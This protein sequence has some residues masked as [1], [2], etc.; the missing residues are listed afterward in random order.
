MNYYIEYKQEALNSVLSN[1]LFHGS[2]TYIKGS[3][4]PHK[5]F[6]YD[7]Y[8]YATSDYSYALVRAGKFDIDNFAIKEDYNGVIYTLV[9]LKENAFEEVF[10]TEGY[11]YLVDSKY[12]FKTDKCMP[13]EYISKYKCKI[14]QTFKISNVLEEIKKYENI[15]Y[16]LIAYGSEEE[17]EYWNTVNGGKDGYLKRRKERAKK[18]KGD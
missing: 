2:N 7:K 16:K 12:F 5:S 18:I 8:V 3:L 1:R 13:Y 4:K 6:H 14:I 9:E 10:N 15:H 11:I 17:K